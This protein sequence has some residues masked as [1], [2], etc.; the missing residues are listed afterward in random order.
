ME[1]NQSIIEG[2]IGRHPVDRKKMA[3]LKE[4]GREAATSYKVIERL[5]G[6]TFVEAYPKTGRT[7][8]IRVHLSHI[9]HP[10]AGDDM[11][12][13]KAKHAA[14]RPLLHAYKIE[15]IHPAIGVPVLIEAPVPEDM[16]EFI[17][18]NK[19]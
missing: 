1:K 9:G 3:V 5:D 7:H 6:F 15:F 10:V 18:K 13:K 16:I 17:A 11:Y 4:G 8:Q 19:G 12:G 2:S 14:D